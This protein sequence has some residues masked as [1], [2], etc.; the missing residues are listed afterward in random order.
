MAAREEV[1]RLLGLWGAQVQW[2]VAGALPE[3]GQGDGELGKLEQVGMKQRLDVSAARAGVE[4][5]RYAI[6][7]RRAG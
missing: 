3:P 7:L 4:A 2:K 1:N 6:K 5:M